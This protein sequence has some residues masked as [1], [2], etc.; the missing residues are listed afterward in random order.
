MKILRKCFA[1]VCFAFPYLALSA[2]SA[3]HAQDGGSPPSDAG[4]ARDAADAAVTLTHEAETLAPMADEG[5]RAKVVPDPQET[6]EDHAHAHA[7]SYVHE[8]AHSAAEP[9][10]HEY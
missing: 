5:S 3:V 2:A 9:H 6:R 7:H 1:F 4:V 10:G 8:H